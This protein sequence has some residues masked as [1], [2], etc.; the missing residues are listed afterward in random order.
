MT[1][2]SWRHHSDG[3]SHVRNRFSTRPLDA[4]VAKCPPRLRSARNRLQIESQQYT[5]T[6]ILAVSYLTPG[7][8]GLEVGMISLVSVHCDWVRQQV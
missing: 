5:P 8:M 7:A 6:D 1:M 4:L 3:P 2:T